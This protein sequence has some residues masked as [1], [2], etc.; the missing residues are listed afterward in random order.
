MPKSNKKSKAIV[1]VASNP[2]EHVDFILKDGSCKSLKVYLGHGAD[3]GKLFVQCDL[4]GTF[5][6]LG[7]QRSLNNMQ[8]HYNQRPCQDKKTKKEWELTVLCF[9]TTNSCCNT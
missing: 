9:F 4:C 1:A 2:P 6:T 8:F 5:I 3:L 7:Q